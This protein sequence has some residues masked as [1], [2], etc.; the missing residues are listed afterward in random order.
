MDLLSISLVMPF[1]HVDTTTST[2]SK[3]VI[4][5]SLPVSVL[6]IPKA[7]WPKLL[8]EISTVHIAQP[9]TASL[10]P[11]RFYIQTSLAQLDVLTITE[12][13]NNSA[14][15]GGICTHLPFQNVL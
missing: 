14:S 4:S 12:L 7:L 5:R 9:L 13:H 8:R 1:E 6:T 10:C 2:M 11:P 3:A 15:T